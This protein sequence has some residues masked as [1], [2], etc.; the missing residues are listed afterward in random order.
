MN[1]WYKKYLSKEDLQA[2]ASAIGEAEKATS[3]EI[4]VVVRHRRH[5]G[6]G[7]MSLHEIALK[8]FHKLGMDRTRDGTG[9]L[10]LVL[11]SKRQFHIIADRGINTKVADGTWDAIAGQMTTYFKK[12]D[13]GTGIC[14]AVV[15]AGKILAANFPRK[16]DDTNELPNDVI[17]G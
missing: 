11:F 13:Y 2:I 8:E 14:K 17:E 15:E 7:R 6:E 1:L 12:G 3:G 16:D 10:I 9:V 5:W 4:R